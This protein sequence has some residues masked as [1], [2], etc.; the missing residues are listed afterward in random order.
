MID[1]M[2]ALDALQQ[3][4]KNGLPS[5]DGCYLESVV[6][7]LKLPGGTLDLLR[8]AEAAHRL[9]PVN[10][11]PPLTL[12]AVVVLRAAYDAERSGASPPAAYE[13]ATGALSKYL[14]ILPVSP[15]RRRPRPA[16]GPAR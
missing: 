1:V 9:W 3:C 16:G 7:T 4:A 11:P 10:A 14:Y 13:Q 15:S 5:T 8:S 12:G 2:T 6:R